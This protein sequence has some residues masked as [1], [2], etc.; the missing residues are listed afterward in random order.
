MVHLQLI[1]IQVSC[2]WNCNWNIL[3]IKWLKHEDEELIYGLIF[4]SLLIS[5]SGLIF[6]SQRFNQTIYY[7]QYQQKQQKFLYSGFCFSFIFYCHKW[8]VLA[9][10]PFTPWVSYISFPHKKRC[11]EKRRG[12]LWHECNRCK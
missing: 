4:L 6:E 11:K 12:N 5:T 8:K 3:G 10:F 1:V 9:I 2:Y 7:L